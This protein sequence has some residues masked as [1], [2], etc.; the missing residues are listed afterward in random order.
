MSGTGDWKQFREGL[1]IAV[2][3]ANVPLWRSDAAQLGDIQ[4]IVDAVLEKLSAEIQE[5]IF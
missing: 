4:R 5:F 1:I 2:F 3:E